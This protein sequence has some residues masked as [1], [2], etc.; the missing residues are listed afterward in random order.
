MGRTS[1]Q[2]RDRAVKIAGNVMSTGGV[3]I[4]VS[5]IGCVVSWFL[6]EV[7]T[8]IMLGL[9]VLGIILVIVALWI[10]EEAD[11]YG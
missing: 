5:M 3:L 1:K 10:E 11:Y 4:A 7:V 6:P 8:A 9:L 2:R